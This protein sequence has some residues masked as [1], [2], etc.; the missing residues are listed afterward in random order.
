MD[1]TKARIACVNVNREGNPVTYMD[2]AAVK[3]IRE[4][5]RKLEELEKENTA[6]RIRAVQAEARLRESEIIAA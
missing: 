6:L 5:E 4:L 3:R 1:R 2:E